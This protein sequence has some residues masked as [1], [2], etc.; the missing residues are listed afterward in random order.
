[1]ES[2]ACGTQE[3]DGGSVLDYP[4]GYRRPLAEIFDEF[5]GSCFALID[6]HIV[7]PT[8]NEAYPLF[9]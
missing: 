9:I 4:G 6:S 5:G 7:G 2:R 8:N 3:T 1:M